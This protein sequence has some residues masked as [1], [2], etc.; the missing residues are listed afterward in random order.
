[1]IKILQRLVREEEGQAL[2]EYGLVLAGLAVAVVFAIKFL[3]NDLMD[4]FEDIM[5]KVEEAIGKLEVK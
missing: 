1:M 5:K 4:I 2:V 3:G